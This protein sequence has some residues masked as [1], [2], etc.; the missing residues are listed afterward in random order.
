[1]SIHCEDIKA[2]FELL[3]ESRDEFG[4]IFGDRGKY[5]IAIYQRL[6]TAIERAESKTQTRVSG[7]MSEVARLEDSDDYS[8]KDE[9]DFGQRQNK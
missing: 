7:G 2:W 9:I 1:M 6:N 3:K 8:D 5:H 4:R